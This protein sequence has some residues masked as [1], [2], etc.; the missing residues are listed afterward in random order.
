MEN[1]QTKFEICLFWITLQITP[2]RV[3]DKWNLCAFCTTIFHQ[4][5]RIRRGFSLFFTKSHH[6]Y[7]FFKKAHLI[8]FCNRKGILI[9]IKQVGARVL[10]YQTRGTLYFWEGVHLRSFTKQGWAGDGRDEERVF[11]LAVPAMGFHFERDVWYFNWC[12]TC[13]CYSLNVTGLSMDKV[14][15]FLYPSSTLGRTFCLEFI[16][17][18]ILNCFKDSDI[19]MYKY[20]WHC[21]NGW[22]WILQMISERY[23]FFL[24]VY[25]LLGG[26]WFTPSILLIKTLDVFILMTK[27]PTQVSVFNH[28]ISCLAVFKCKTYIQTKES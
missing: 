3:W 21:K 10:V 13:Q 16:T 6:N 25:H 5:S 22:H 27:H 18:W 28:T 26:T 24:F 2:Q 8:Y 7:K 1:S 17:Q 11:T 23:V 9:S 15:R 4:Y 19:V 14:I 20:Y 12:N